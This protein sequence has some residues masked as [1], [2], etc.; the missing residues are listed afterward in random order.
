MRQHVALLADGRVLVDAS[1]A[2]PVLDSDDAFAM[3]DA[4]TLVGADIPLAPSERLPD[5][6]LLHVVGTRHRRIGAGALVPAEH[7]A[8]PALATAIA[9]AVTELDEPPEGRPA[10]FRRGWYERLEAWIDASL[11]ATGRHRTG[12]VEPVKSWS[13]SAVVRVPVEGGTVWCKQPSTHFGAEARIHRAVAEIEPALLPEI[14]ASEEAD[15]LL[16]LEPMLGVEAA[17]HADGAAEHV[18]ARWA[19]AQ[20]D[21]VAHVPALLEAGLPLRDADATLTAFRDLL[22]HGRELDLLSGDELR[23][24]RACA[25]RIE[26]LVRELWSTGIPDTLAHG[27]LHLDNVAW[28]GEALRLFDWTDACIS[29]PFL[30]LAHLTRSMESTGAGDAALEEVREVYAERWR[31][32]YPDADVDR[33]LVLAPLVDRVFQTVTFEAIARATEERSAWELRGIIARNLR[34]LPSQLPDER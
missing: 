5:G 29:H 30:D 21:A 7:L 32:A 2:L 24:V 27:D 17:Q 19:A 4:L 14:I 20:R 33:A 13:M 1:G 10:W 9:R 11:S 26:A 8:D 16:L 3:A 12:P 23:A 18:A 22:A 28:D 31:S 15:G 25:E 34:A 6:S